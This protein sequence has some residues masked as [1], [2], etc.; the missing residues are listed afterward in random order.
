MM[1]MV[2]GEVLPDD[3]PIMAKL[4]GVWATTTLPQRRAYHRVM[5]ANSRDAFDLLMVRGV[6]D[7]LKASIKETS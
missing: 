4:L 7:R 6:I 5:C 3:H 2:T 1:D